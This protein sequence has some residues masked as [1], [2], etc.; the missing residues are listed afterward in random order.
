MISNVLLLS[1][2]IDIGTNSTIRQAK[3]IEYTSALAI[4]LLTIIDFSLSFNRIF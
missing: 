3:N 1:F 2:K 4:K